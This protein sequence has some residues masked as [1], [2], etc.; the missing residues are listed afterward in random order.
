M[1]NCFQTPLHRELAR[2]TEEW[3]GE[4]GVDTDVVH[5]HRQTCELSGQV[6]QIRQR[7]RLHG[8][9]AGCCSGVLMLDPWLI[10]S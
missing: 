8:S 6:W 10:P 3:Y 5:K 7:V 9:Q 1:I 2:D 4:H